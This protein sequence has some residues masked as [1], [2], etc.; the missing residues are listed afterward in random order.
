MKTTVETVSLGKGV[1]N[2]DR[3]ERLSDRYGTVGLTEQAGDYEDCKKQESS[4]YVPFEKPVLDPLD[5]A[6]GKLVAV[7]LETRESQHVG[8]FFHSVSPSTPQ[9]GDR[10][11]LGE[12]NFFSEPSGYFNGFVVG[13]KPMD[14]RR[15]LWL[16]IRALYRCHDQTVELLLEK[17]PL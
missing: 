17:T 2:W 13:V 14:G 5:G 10:I 16:S 15:T 12:G 1:L 4:V 11:P 9:V 7:I 8:D 3:S 6:H